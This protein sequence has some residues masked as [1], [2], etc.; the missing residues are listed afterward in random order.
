MRSAVMN[1][2]HNAVKF[3]PPN[4]AVVITFANI[5]DEPKF[6]VLTVADQG[7]GR[8][9]SERDRVFDRFFTSSARES[10]SMASSGIGLSIAKLAVERS[11]GKILFDPGP[12]EGARCVI[13][14]PLED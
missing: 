1:I 8:R 14:L 9:E 2:L 3:S 6:A 10:S 12:A 7:P 4:F 11:G 5:G 13:R